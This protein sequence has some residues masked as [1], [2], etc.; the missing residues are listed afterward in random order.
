VS[1]LDIDFPYFLQFDK[2]A[3]NYLHT[4]VG[5]L[6]LGSADPVAPTLDRLALPG[7][8]GLSRG[9]SWITYNGFNLLWLPADYRPSSRFLFAISATTVAIGCSSGRVIFLELS[10][11][12]PL[13]GVLYQ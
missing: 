3:S 10:E 13:S 12:N 2:I 9:L 11:R 7:A 8:Y 4:N 5:T 1:T 6:D